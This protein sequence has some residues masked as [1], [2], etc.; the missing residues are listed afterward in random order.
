VTRLH[1]EHWGHE[2]AAGRALLLPGITSSAATMWEVAEGLAAAGWSA[3]A[4][5][6]PG[7]GGTGPAGSYRFADVADLVAAQLGGGW[8]LVVGHS[9]GG[10][11]ATV[12]LAAHPSVATR[13]LLVDPALVVSDDAADELVRQLE[14]D[15]VDQTEASV[16]AAHPHW[17]PRTVTERVRSTRG[18]DVTAVA[19]FAAQNRPWDVRDRAR[20]V[21]VP[22]HVLVPTEDAVVT[23][24]LVEELSAGTRAPWTFQTVAGTGHSMHRDRPAVVVARALLPPAAS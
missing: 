9:L 20:E 19:G 4:V 3:V 10:A 23:A 1:T 6:L 18:T 13:A 14:R 12:L 17:H 24:G 5:D 8:D 22:V 2:G 7:H 16:A 21:P 15:R 11:V